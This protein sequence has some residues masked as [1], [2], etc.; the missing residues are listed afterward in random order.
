MFDASVMNAA[1]AV[2]RS[3]C[4]PD[5]DVPTSECRRVLAADL[6][7]VRSLEL[8]Y[9]LLSRELKFDFSRFNC[10]PLAETLESSLVGV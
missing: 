1:T 7:S 10:C 6:A 9:F 3:P 5:D 8:R 2:V 4:L